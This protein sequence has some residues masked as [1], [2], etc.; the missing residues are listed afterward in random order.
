ML[1]LARPAPAPA[2]PPPGP[3]LRPPGR[4]RPPRLSAPADR[5]Q[6]AVTA[7]FADGRRQDVTRLACYE[8]SEPRVAEV[9]PAGVVV[10]REPGETA[11]Q[12]RFLGVQAAVRLAFVPERPDFTWPDPPA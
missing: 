1:S 2:R 8:L 11:V 6:I 9:S 7:V 10:R 12:V 5:V 3:P 4:S